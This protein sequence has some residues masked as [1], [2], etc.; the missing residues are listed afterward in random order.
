MV[1]DFGLRHRFHFTIGGVLCQHAHFR[2]RRS[3]RLSRGL[4]LLVARGHAALD[5]TEMYR[6]K[7]EGFK[8]TLLNCVAFEE[9]DVHFEF[10]VFNNKSSAIDVY[11]QAYTKIILEKNDI[12]KVEHDTQIANYSIYTLKARGTYNVAIY[13]GNTAVYAYC[14]EENAEQIASI[15]RE[16]GY[17]S[18]KK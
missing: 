3:P 9:D 18:P 17:F 14:N 2:F 15:L 1:G 11:G 10:F 8:E 4:K 5:I 16:I 6:E 7:D 12:A 13:V